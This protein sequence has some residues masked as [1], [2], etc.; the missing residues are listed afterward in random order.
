VKR[1]LLTAGPTPVPDRIQ[2][3]MAREMIHHRHPE[4]KELFKECQDGLRWLFQTA[5]TPLV[6]TCSGTGAMEGAVVNFLSPG[7]EAIV[8][9][10]GK[11]GERWTKIAKA[12][13]VVSHEVAVEW[14]Q[15]VDPAAVKQAL[16]AHPAAKAVYVQASETSTG[17][18]HP[19]K[20]LAALTAARADTILVVDAIT[21]LG[22]FDLPADAWGL[23]VV[24]TGSQKA[25]MLPPGLAFASVS[26]KAWRL[27]ETARCPRFY[28]DW[29]KERKEQEAV[30]VAF[31]PAVG[32]FVGLREALRMMKEEGLE[33]VFARHDL[34]A[35]A[36][37]A[38]A[39]AL[40]LELYAGAPA[41]SVTAVC[42]PAGVDGEKV[43][44]HL[45]DRYGVAI[46]GGQD[47]AKGKIVRLAHLGYFDKFDIVTALA[48]LEMTL[49]DLGHPVTRGAAVAAAE[50]VFAGGAK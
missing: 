46:A 36:T 34:L 2:L 32:L 26:D 22:V 48:A 47:R 30:T 10:G 27:N 45:R 41:P 44:K 13:G 35:R 5:R 50:A 28:F 1:Y 25:L 17:A 6:F 37:R 33:N 7:D 3:A 39:Q 23:D 14:G 49:N 40:G 8:V 15:G 21:A 29:K 16:D 11:F 12:Y 24:V 18:V 9:N 19:V 4:F 38:G 42:T 31:T 20:E 43:V